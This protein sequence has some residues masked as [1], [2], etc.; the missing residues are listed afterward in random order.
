MAL[1]IRRAFGAGVVA[2]VAGF[3]ATY[4]VLRMAFD[5]PVQHLQNQTRELFEPMLSEPNIYSSAIDS[6]TTIDLTAWA[7][8]SAHFD[9]T[10]TLHENNAVVYNVL[11]MFDGPVVILLYAIPVLAIVMAGYYVAKKETAFADGSI[12]AAAGAYIALGYVPAAILNV[13][14]FLPETAIAQVVADQ[15][16]L[17]VTVVI[18]LIYAGILGAIGGML[19][20]RR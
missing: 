18:S 3:A 9:G 7:Y 12:D 15:Y 8:H 20:G 10:G 5:T 6:M 19:A 4:F 11:T 17:T 16:P 1:P 2:Y 14:I 13:I